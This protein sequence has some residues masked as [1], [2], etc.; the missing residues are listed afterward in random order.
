MEQLIESEQKAN[1]EVVKTNREMKT[2]KKELQMQI[3]FYHRSLK[4]YKATNS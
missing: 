3:Y 1:L 2:L 4:L